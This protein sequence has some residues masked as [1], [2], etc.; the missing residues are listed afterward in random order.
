MAG[1]STGITPY[2]FTDEAARNAY[3]V[4]NPSLLVNGAEAKTRLMLFQYNAGISQ[5]VAAGPSHAQN[6]NAFEI[7]GAVGA[8]PYVVT[9][10]PQTALVAYVD[11]AITFNKPASTIDGGGFSFYAVRG[12]VTVTATTTLKEAFAFGVRANCVIAGVIDQTSAT[13]VGAL[14]AKLDVS[15]ATITAGQ[16]SVAWF[17]WGQTATTPTSTECNVIRVQNTTT[18]VIN[19]LI[20]GYGKAT[21]FADVSDNSGG[22]AVATA[23]TTLSGSLKVHVNGNVRY[24]ALY[25]NPS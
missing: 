1:E 21:Y 10:S 20:Y 5:W 4:A 9:T 17:D 3:F 25:T 13:R 12:T 2:Y 23:P 15:A 16:V 18:A 8:Q 22:W 14:F 19:S 24:I 11:P 6:L 7:S